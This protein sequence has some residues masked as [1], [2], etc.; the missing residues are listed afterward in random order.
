MLDVHQLEVLVEIARVGSYTEAAK[1]LGYTQPAVSYHMRCLQRAVGVPLTVKVGRKAQLTAAAVKLAEQ[2][3]TVLSGLRSV[4]QEFRAFTAQSGGQIRLSAIQSACTSVVPGA[5]A[6]LRDGWPNVEV[7]LNQAA[8]PVSYRLLRSGEVDLAIMCD[9]DV[10]DPAQQTV[11]PEADLLRIPLLTDRRCVLLP[12]NHPLAGRQALSLAELSGE[13][14]ILETGRTRFLATC[15]EAGFEPKIVATTD[16][17]GTIHRLVSSH[18]GVA[19]MYG[20]GLLPQ[21]DDS[22]VVRPLSD[23]PTRR[24]FALLWPDLFKLPAVSAL[25]SALRAEVKERF[26]A[27]GPAGCDE[28]EPRLRTR[29]ILPE[30]A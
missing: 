23:W 29:A 28:A 14:W 25:V 24:V 20:L 17:Q 16:D 3:E 10:P 9:L 15:A 21:Q 4:E 27:T 8:C 7:V 5:M 19:T 18:V 30:A 11:T 26:P 1:S 13:R 22:V 6:R 2:A 12:S